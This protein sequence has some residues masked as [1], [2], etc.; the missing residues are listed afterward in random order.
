MIVAFGHPALRT[1]S[2][3][4]SLPALPYPQAAGISKRVGG[5]LGEPY[6]SLNGQSTFLG[7]K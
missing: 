7:H 1:A 2:W 4:E 6:F 3:E 5:L